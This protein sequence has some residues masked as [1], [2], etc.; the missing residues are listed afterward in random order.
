MAH[1]DSD[2]GTAAPDAGQQ[3]DFGTICAEPPG[4]R[5]DDERPDGSAELL[6]SMLAGAK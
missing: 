2:P 3:I 1:L 6:R 5:Q 4:V